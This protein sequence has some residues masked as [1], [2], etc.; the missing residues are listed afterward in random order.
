MLKNGLKNR[1]YI[2]VISEHLEPLKLELVTFLSS[3]GMEKC[4]FSDSISPWRSIPS[5]MIEGLS[6][7]FEKIKSFKI[8]FLSNLIK[9]IIQIL[10]LLDN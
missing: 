8:S 4:F 10:E 5:L 9:S 6:K 7:I 2:D 1:I 3:L